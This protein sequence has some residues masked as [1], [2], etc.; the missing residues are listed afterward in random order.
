MPA[1]RN[2]LVTEIRGFNRYYTC[3]IGLLDETL[4][5]S[6]YTLG[7]A[8]LLFEL[9]HRSR[10]AANSDGEAGFLARAFHLDLGPAASE[11]AAELRLDPAYV[12]RVLRKFA[13]AGLTETCTDPA[14]RRRH[15]VSLT[16][17]GNAELARLQA[18][19][20][21]DLARL[22][23]GLADEQA[24]ELSDALKRVMRLL[25]EK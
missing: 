21:R 14:D 25:G 3:L 24:A 19:A 20:D 17:Q 9:G 22:T 10:A 1:E 15:V 8:R 6:A 13:A 4:T 5:H 18:A 11:I 7:E 23:A 12:T 2:A 16:A